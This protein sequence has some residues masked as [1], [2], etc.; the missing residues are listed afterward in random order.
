M[1]GWG[2]TT[3]TCNTKQST[4]CTYQDKTSF[5]HD[6]LNWFGSTPC[7]RHAIFL[8]LSRHVERLRWGIWARVLMLWLFCA[9][10]FCLWRI[11]N[12]VLNNTDVRLLMQIYNFMLLIET[13]SSIY[14][15]AW[16]PSNFVLSFT[17]VFTVSQNFARLSEKPSEIIKHKFYEDP[18]R[19]IRI[20]II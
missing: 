7:R 11:R 20:N 2:R 10:I 3:K 8:N 6:H 19:F 9:A 5:C 16:C 4:A 12:S 15:I 18:M 1:S 17:R 13:A 14:V